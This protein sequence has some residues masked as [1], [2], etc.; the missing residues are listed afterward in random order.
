MENLESQ[1]SKNVDPLP[2]KGLKRC[3][4]LVNDLTQTSFNPVLIQRLTRAVLGIGGL[5]G[6]A[7]SGDYVV[8]PAVIRVCG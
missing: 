3:V 6:L 5:W 7:V 8:G 2:F 1:T 4:P